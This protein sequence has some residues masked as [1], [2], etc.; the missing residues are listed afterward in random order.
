MDFA[1]FFL[2]LA[3][4]A[5]FSGSEASLFGIGRG[6]VSRLR[7][8]ERRTERLVGRLLEGPRDLLVTVLLGNEV[9][10]VALSAVSAWIV[11]RRLGDLSP[12]AQAALAVAVALP[13]LLVV[14]EVTPRTLAAPRAERLARVL[15]IPLCAW[16]LL[17]T[18]VRR[19]L[20]GLTGAVVRRLGGGAEPGAGLDEQEFRTLVELG[21]EAGV[22][23]KQEATLIE[24][25]LDFDDLIVRDVMIPADRIFS[26]AESTPIDEA[27][28][29]A[30]ERKYSR[31][32]VWR[33][34]PR[35]IVGVVYA[36]DLLAQRWGSGPPRSLRQLMRRPYFVLPKM[37]CD[38]LLEAFRRKR[39]HM[40]IVVD[41]FG[42]A[43]G[44]CTME[45]LLEE[46]FGPIT[47]VQAERKGEE[48]RP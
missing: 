11:W 2:L 28:R 8:S 33:D 48:A 22:V 7:Q 10:N 23:E 17:A 3:L 26:L 44:L 21:A 39:M 35:N 45:D 14:G 9:T 30:V 16:R 15:A 18:P 46:L 37:R 13:L 19:V 40:A 6:A 34:H 42:R 5:F 12:V 24:N 41:E 4:S 20:A 27:I 1:L 36:K 43:L 32:P 38:A 47:D 25:V 29:A 31:I